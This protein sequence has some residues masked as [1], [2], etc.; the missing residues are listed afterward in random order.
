MAL[1]TI[2]IVLAVAAAAVGGYVLGLTHGKSRGVPHL[3]ALV[4]GT[5]AVDDPDR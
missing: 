3:D 1:S 4:R 5:S 2:L